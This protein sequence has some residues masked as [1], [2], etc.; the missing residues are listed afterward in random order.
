MNYAHRM[1][2]NY[3]FWNAS[4]LG[5]RVDYKEALRI[6]ERFSMDELVRIYRVLRSRS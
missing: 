6:S 2:V 5:K 4:L 3:V 1:K